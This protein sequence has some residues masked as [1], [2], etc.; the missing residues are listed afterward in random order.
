MLEERFNL[1][2]LMADHAEDT[3]Q[4]TVAN[5]KQQQAAAMQKHISQLKLLLNKLTQDLLP[6]TTADG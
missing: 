5:G 4:A 6:V 3:G 2:S 1:L